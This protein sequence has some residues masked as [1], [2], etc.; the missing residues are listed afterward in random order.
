MD[1]NMAPLQT[2]LDDFGDTD[3]TRIIYYKTFLSQTDYITSKIAEYNYLNKPIE[4]KYLEILNQREAARE[5]IR[6][7]LTK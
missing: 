2:Y 1:F 4:E 7:L 3:E 5:N 6:Q